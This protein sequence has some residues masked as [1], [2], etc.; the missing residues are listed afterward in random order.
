MND[1]PI[2]IPPQVTGIDP[3]PAAKPS[4][5]KPTDGAFEGKLMEA[6]GKVSQD[7]DKI[8]SSTPANVDDI[9]S[10]MNAAKDAFSDTMNM[11]QMM[12]SLI[13]EETKTD[14]E[15]KANG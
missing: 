14:D 6:M 3:A 2:R 9:Q 13:N 11:H 5:P 7:V 8:A 15:G 4:A 12:Q 10:A 1:S